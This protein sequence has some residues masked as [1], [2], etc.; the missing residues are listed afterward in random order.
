MAE[1]SGNSLMLP[2]VLI[3]PIRLAPHSVNQRAPS[4][5]EVIWVGPAL[6]VGRVYSVISPVVVMRPILLAAFSVN[7][8]APSA[9][10]AIPCPWAS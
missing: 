10:E 3:R 2:L 1:R 4:G 9:P 6:A 5:P 7:Q 8:R